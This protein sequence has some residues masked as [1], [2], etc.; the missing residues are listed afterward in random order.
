MIPSTVS[1]IVPTIG[2]PESLARLLESLGKQSYLPFEVLVADGSNSPETA[3]IVQQPCWEALGLNVTRFPTLPP[4]AVRQRKEAIARSSGELL[5]FVDD[6][7]VLEND[8]IE[9]MVGVLVSSPD[10]VCTVARLN[11]EASPNPTKAWRWYLRAFHGLRNGQWN[12]RVVGPLLRFGFN[13]PPTEARRMEWL[14]TGHSM[15]R[16]SAYELSGGFSDFFLHRCTMN[17]DVDLGLKVARHGRI[18]FCPHARVGHFHD[19][20]GRVSISVAAEDDLYN[21]FLVLSRT[22][23]Q[24]S[25]RAL[26]LCLVFF[27]IETASNFLGCLRRRSFRG[28][29]SRLTGRARALALILIEAGRQLA[30]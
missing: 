26:G 7:V 9:N 27:T 1:V 25:A 3:A 2:R 24:S 17:E 11:N 23:G 8:C 30:K 28:F 13:P 19:P 6:D 16:R 12:G 10:T 4:N 29:T 20:G 18:M 22:A 21:R 15:V 5:L 14:T